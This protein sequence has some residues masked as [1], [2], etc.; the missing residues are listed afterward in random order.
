[1]SVAGHRL[2]ARLGDAAASRAPSS[3]ARA[4]SATSVGIGTIIAPTRLPNVPICSGVRTDTGTI[5]TSGSSGS[6]SRS[7]RY[8]RTAVA[9][10]RHDDVVDGDAGLVLDRLDPVER[11]RAEAEAPVRRDAA[12]LKRVRGTVDRRRPEDV[13]RRRRTRAG[14]APARVSRPSV[15]TPGTCCDAGHV[16]EVRELGQL[17]ERAHRLARQAEQRRG[18]ASRAGPGRAR[19]RARRGLGGR[20]FSSRPSGLRSTSA[21][22]I[23]APETPSTAAW[24][25]L[26]STATRPSGRPWMR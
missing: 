15:P 23:S 19:R 8:S 3:A 9:H 6:S 17:L 14:S 10:E 21:L 2:V 24:W 4:W 12:P 18:R 26:V 7:S 22:R 1:M 16:G 20:S 5:E 25:T 11:Q 13:R